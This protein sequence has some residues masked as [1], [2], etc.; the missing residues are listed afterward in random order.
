MAEPKIK[1]KGD[2]DR[3]LTIDDVAAKL[4]CS[5]RQVDRLK[6]HGLTPVTL[7][8]GSFIRYLP[9]EVERWSMIRMVKGAVKKSKEDKTDAG[10]LQK[11][12]G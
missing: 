8:D 1:F 6:A 9:R 7:L 3:L 12:T 4:N 2:R 5:R 10:K 11:K